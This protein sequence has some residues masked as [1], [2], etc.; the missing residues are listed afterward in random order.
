M[1][2]MVIDTSAML[3]ILL[4]EPE[5]KAMAHAVAQD[6]KR[7][8][9]PVAHLECAIVIH[10]RKG[11]AG[12][13]EFDLF[14][15]EARI[16]IPAMDQDQAAMARTAYLKFG[17]GHHPA[18]LNLA[19][20]CSYALATSLGEALLFKGRDFAQTDVRVATY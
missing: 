4:A 2:K 19:D 10:T 9:S 8:T 17:K 20:C 14:L 3:A 1:K 11:P 13:R 16:E 6:G 15:H 18:G 12:L 7:Y 5:A